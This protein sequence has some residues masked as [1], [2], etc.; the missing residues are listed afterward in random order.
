MPAGSQDAAA[1]S[2]RWRCCPHCLAS[3]DQTED[4]PAMRCTTCR[5]VVG[6]GR[7]ITPET[8]KASGRKAGAAANLVGAQARRNRTDPAADTLAAATDVRRVA[9]TLGLAPDRLRMLDYQAASQA[10]P[11]ITPLSS[12]LASFGS[13]KAARGAAVAHATRAGRRARPRAHVDH[14]DDVR[15]T[16]GTEEQ[17]R[18]L[19]VPTASRGSET[20]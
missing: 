5:L 9:D 15:S 14:P 7:S 20:A 3:I 1:A 19:S 17:K 13:W 6:A 16:E 8:A 11:D 2:H 4:G 10:N 18:Q 12:L